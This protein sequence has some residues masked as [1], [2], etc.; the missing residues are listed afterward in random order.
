MVSDK[1]LINNSFRLEALVEKAVEKVSETQPWPYHFRLRAQELE[2]LF[3]FL[4]MSKVKRMLEVGCGN[5]FGSVLFSDKADKIVATDLPGYNLDTS[6][7][8][9]DYAKRLI[10]ALNIDNISLLASQAEE[11][12]FADESFDLVFSAYVLEHLANKQKAIDEIRRILK[13]GGIAI[14]IVPNF[15][16]RLYAPL[17]FYP[18][19]FQ[20]GVI[21]LFKLLG[22]SFKGRSNT[23]VASKEDKAGGAPKPF[24]NRLKKFLKDYPNFPFCGPHGNYKCWREE[25]LAHLPEKWKN[26]FESNGLK[27]IGLYSTMFVPHN[28]LSIFSE[29]VAYFIYSKSISLTKKIGKSPI[30]KY[31]GYSLCLVVQK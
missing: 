3:D 31:L 29:K 25:F 21:Y 4:N 20:R 14:A 16:E 28:F 23:V 8:G 9:L 30:F 11:L 5:A 1:N 13:K 17:H 10:R 26:L 7:I 18:Y 2:L 27:V 24:L 12:P 19:L 22:L 6:S 15:M